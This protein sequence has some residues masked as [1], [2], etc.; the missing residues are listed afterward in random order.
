MATLL[1]TDTTIDTLAAAR[2]LAPELSDRALETETLG[3]L[4]LDLVNK[5]RDAHLF[6]L[7][8]PRTLGGLGLG[9][10]PSSPPSRNCAA[11]TARAG[12]RS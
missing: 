9:P 7:S 10:A 1:D 2:A 6:D 8:T 4:P 11:P 5:A 12:G 3:T